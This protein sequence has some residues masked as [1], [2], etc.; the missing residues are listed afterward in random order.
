MERA[1]ALEAFQ[2][3]LEDEKLLLLQS[4]AAYQSKLA[5]DAEIALVWNN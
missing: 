4:T 1:A 5:R 3:K 2:Q